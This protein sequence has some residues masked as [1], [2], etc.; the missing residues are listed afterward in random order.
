MFSL[1]LLTFHDPLILVKLVSMCFRHV[2]QNKRA[3]VNPFQT[4]GGDGG[5]GMIKFSDISKCYK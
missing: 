2:V 1:M 4:S 5:G 3:T